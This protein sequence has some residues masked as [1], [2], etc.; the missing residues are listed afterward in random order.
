VRDETQTD[1]AMRIYAREIGTN[2]QRFMDAFYN[3]PVM[4]LEHFKKIAQALFTLANQLSTSAFQNIQQARVIADRQK[5]EENLLRLST[6][7]NQTV[8][9]VVITDAQG[10]IQYVNPAFETITG[11]LKN[12]IIGQNPRVL[13]SGRH[14]AAFYRDLWNTISAGQ[15]WTGRFINKR[16]NGSLYTEDATISP[17]RDSTGVITNYVAVK[18][19]VTAELNKEEE[20][21]QAQKMETVGQLAGG[22]AHDFNN[23]LQAILGF[24]E[25]LLSTLNP[26]TSEYRNVSEIKKATSRATDITRQL[27]TFGRKQP[28]DKKQLDIN[29][30]IQD[31]DV[32]LQILLGDKIQRTF[33]LA[34]DIPPI[35]ADFGQMTQIIMNLA[36][37]ARDAMPEGGRL[38]I[39][40]E[41]IHLSPSDLAVIP[42]SEPG[43]FVCLS[44]TDTG[45]GMNQGVKDHLFE[46][47]F[48]TKEPGKGTG[49]GLAGIY[50]IIKKHNGWITVYSEENHGT[51]FKVYLPTSPIAEPSAVQPD[52]QEENHREHILLVEDDLA[53]S[54]LVISIL[55][56]AGYQTSVTSSAE[57]ALL[58]FNREQAKFD[59]LFSDI[60]LPG[61][62]GIELADRIRET[63][64]ALPVL[65]YS[66]YRDQRE[67][68]S[69][70]D[71]K[72]YH[73]LQK[74]FTVTSLLAA[75]YDTLNKTK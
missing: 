35:N 48:T 73:F 1:E 11:Y 19:D 8:E 72:G 39:S 58:L 18:R 31:T 25:L 47:F 46:P 45:C 36:I 69:S 4:S 16:K 67:R 3:V 71:T 22:V 21:R 50:G 26:E 74:P 41:T 40:T 54:N 63:H 56:D 32:L 59:M 33:D 6:A 23:I 60:V 12:D 51:T 34:Q 38:T 66:G 37:N 5:A 53:L 30:I 9:A 17:M 52:K 65:L 57:E 13:K 29:S 43:E 62:T 20:Y 70:L 7:I 2:E 15:T 75:V 55:Q 28:V 61:E 10:I 24:S 42:G 64:P 14:E 49:L 68:W 27:L 44:M